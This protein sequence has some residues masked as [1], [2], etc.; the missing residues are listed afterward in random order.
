MKNLILSVR[1][2]YIFALCIIITA[3]YGQD[4]NDSGRHVSMDFN[5]K[6][7]LGDA[8]GANNPQFDDSTW[9][10]VNIP[11]DY[12]IE[13]EFNKD[14]AS[15]TGYLP[16]GIGWYR[17]EFTLPQSENKKHV[18]IQ[19][20]GVYENSEVWING[21]YL[22]KR[23]Y[24]FIS[25]CYDLTPYIKFGNEKNV[26]AVRVDNSQVADSRWY[27]GSGIYRSVWLN[28]TDQVHVAQWGTYVTTP[29]INKNSADVRV[30]TK[31]ENDSEG[32]KVVTLKS[33]VVNSEGAT[34]GESSS[35]LTF[36]ANSGY[37]YDHIVKVENI[38]SPPN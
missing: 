4:F 1:C 14:C 19:F 26:I 24:G 20:D 38:E 30:I 21:H 16:G 10:A 13:Q 2:V 15:G 7:N 25:F 36:Q 28:I 27:T 3:S 12:S 31:I 11:H 5:W 8:A 18:E 33:V 6:F 23:P 32:Q 9:R 37:D 35:D 34:I 17:K 29:V 22:G